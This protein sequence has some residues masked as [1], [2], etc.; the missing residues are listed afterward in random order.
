MNQ[1]G[2]GKVAIYRKKETEMPQNSKKGKQVEQGI[3][4]RPS[5]GGY[6]AEVTLRDLLTG[7]R[8]RKIKSTNR[9]DLA[10]QWIQTQ[11]TDAIRSEIRRT[12]EREVKPFRHYAKEYLECWS[13]V[14]KA[15]STYGRDQNSM[16]HLLAHFDRKLLSEISRRDVDAYVAG[17]KST[18]A[19]AGTINRE[20][21][22]LKNMLRKAV[23]WE[24]LKVSPATGVRQQREEV[25]EIIFLTEV[26]LA[27]VISECP[28]QLRTL[29]T[30]AANT[31]MR[32][33]EL[34]KLEWGDV[35]LDRT[36]VTVRKTKNYET[37]HIPMNPVVRR[38]L[39][40]HPKRVAGGSAVP[41]VFSGPSGY[42]LKSI[43]NGFEAAVRRAGIDRHIRFHDLRHTFASRLV[44]KGV[45]MRTVAKL[46]GHRD[47]R[48]TMRYAHLAPE[49][50]QSA[51]DSLTLPEQATER[52]TG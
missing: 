42:Q 39:Q 47:L 50:L 8:I 14:E 19:A 30:V 40:E 6:L 16:K 23:E 43:R 46:L 49:H 4:H 15:A 29:V 2:T 36:M 28:L 1:Q 3:W 10:R 31:G 27:L 44:M 5:G 26:E 35:D 13:K 41:W 51:V 21:S 25:S 52:C 22:C 34:F 12:K 7:R 32:R 48:V 9:L 45:D 24:Y 20:M 38:A 33:G 17:R 18:G 37:R 11:K